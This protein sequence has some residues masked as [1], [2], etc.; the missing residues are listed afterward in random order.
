[1]K[2]SFYDKSLSNSKSHRSKVDLST[3]STNGNSVMA[4]L[5]IESEYSQSSAPSKKV[6]GNTNPY[7]L[8]GYSDSFYEILQSRKKLPAWE[9][10]GY[11][12]LEFLKQRSNY[13]F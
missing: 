3:V 8:R 9:G 4:F 10:K 11:D 6:K 7:T 12:N 2:N 13:S 5:K 1:M